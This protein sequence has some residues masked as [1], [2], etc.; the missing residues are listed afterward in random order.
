MY[1]YLCM[2]QDERHQYKIVSYFFI[3]KDS[4]RE[5]IPRSCP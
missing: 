5:R 4:F 2:G 3:P 1:V